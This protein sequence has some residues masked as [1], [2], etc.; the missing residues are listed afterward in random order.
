LVLFL[1]STLLALGPTASES[2]EGASLAEVESL[3]A[4]GRIM[5]ARGTL[6]TWWTTRFS[7]ASRSDRQRGIWLR[8]K[9]TVDPSMA[10][11]DFR[12]L[13]LEF[14]GGPYTDD[15][16]F[17]LGL[18]ADRKGELREAQGHF[19]RLVR[20][21]PSSPRVQEARDWI[22]SHRIELEALTEEEPPT[23]SAAE[24]RPT[25][26]SLAEERGE[27]TVQLGA[28]R[29]LERALSLAQEVRDAGQDPRVVRTPGNDLARVRVGRFSSREAAVQLARLLEGR[30]FEVTLAT[31][32]GSEERIG[33]GRAGQDPRGRPGHPRGRPGP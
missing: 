16:L 31:D 4:Q 25:T 5:E 19:D 13:V 20:E 10:E 23:E 14:P 26:I 22:R 33:G 29:S 24:P 30:G 3:M 21:Y 28:F 17:R 18:S 9:L 15:A 32:A 8:G 11:L 1:A 2:Q 7:S 12:R 27:F 6:E